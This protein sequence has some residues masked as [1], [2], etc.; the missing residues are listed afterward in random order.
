MFGGWGNGSGGND[1]ANQTFEFQAFNL[2]VKGFENLEIV[3]DGVV[4]DPTDNAVVATND[5]VVTGAEDAVVFGSVLD[6]DSVPDG[7]GT[8]ELVTGPA[9]GNLT[10]NGDGTFSFDPGNAFDH[11]AAGETA[12]E[13]FTYRVTDADGDVDEGLVTITVTGTNDGPVAAA[14][15]VG[16]ALE[17]T[18]LTIPAADL[19]A[20]DTDAD[21][22]DV[23]T[24]GAVGDPVGGTV[25]LDGNGDV[26]FTPAADYSGAA[27]FTY[28]AV[29]VAGAQSTATVTF[30]IDAVADQPT[31]T[32]Q[33]VTGQAGQPVTLDIASALTDTDGSEILGLT[34]S[35]LPAGTLLSAGTANTDGSFSLTAGDLAGLTATLPSGAQGDID[36]T[37]TATSTEQ[38]NGASA[39]VTAAFVLTLP[40]GNAAP[41]DIVLDA[42]P[43]PENETGWIV[44]NLTVVD[45]DVGDTHALAVSDNRFEVVGG[46]LKLKDGVALDFEATPSVSVDV[47]ATDA[48]GLTYTETFV[49]TV[50]DVVN[51][52]MISDPLHRNDCCVISDG[53]G[54]L[55]GGLK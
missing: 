15:V 17:D 51:S 53:G 5:A 18:P 11:L 14:D 55:S 26:V 31:L 47:T 41:T 34:V 29:D 8:V 44:G 39:A 43:I 48:G 52:P 19:L 9:Q 22:N 49:V 46:Q 37:V 27:S 36:V 4:I 45:P 32:V 20:N 28:T 35:G 6:N 23:L 10:F 1:I 12:T 54:A 42:D 3:V 24:I 38:T 16:N 13:T 25:A 7:V 33:D 2:D 50:E 30:E 40:A 21:V